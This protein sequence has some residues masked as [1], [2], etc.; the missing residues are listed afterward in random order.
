MNEDKLHA[1]VDGHASSAERLEIEAELAH[2]PEAAARVA[3]YKRQNE[4]LRALL[5]P[6]LD[7]PHSLGIASR[8]RSRWQRW[9]G[10]AATLALGFVGGYLARGDLLGGPRLEPIARQAMLAHAAYVPEVRHPV[11]VGATEEQHLLAW[12]SKRLSTP[13]RAPALDAAGY[14]L[15]GGRLLPATQA[16]D[17]APMALLMYENARGQRLSLL[18]K[19]ESTNTETAFRY[20]DDRGTCVFYW[21]DGPLGYALA[22]DMD[23]NELQ[24]VA[25]LVYRQLNP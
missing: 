2:D 6:M 24:K 4:A 18:I 15:L 13:L 20:A 5:D 19:R 10:L 23:R 8:S 21:I 7:E 12:L 22:G 14:H 1:Y 16:S 25:R 11:E 17:P 9:G 3:D